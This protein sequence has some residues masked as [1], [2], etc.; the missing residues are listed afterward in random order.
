MAKKKGNDD[1]RE[2]IKTYLKYHPKADTA[3]IEE[4]YHFSK[5]RHKRQLRLSKEPYIVHP[6]GAAKIIAEYRSDEVMIAATLLHDVLEDTPVDYKQLRKL[7]GKEICQL[8][9]G[10]TN[11]DRAAFKSRQENNIANLEKILE[12]GSKDIRVVLI[13]LAD[14][15]DNMKTLGFVPKEKQKRI[16]VDVLA[17]Y[18]PLAHR[19]GLYRIGSELEDLAFQ[20]IN[21]EKYSD[22]KKKIEIKRKVKRKEINKAIKLLKK[23][24][25]GKD[26]NFVVYDKSI[27]STYHKMLHHGKI[28]AEIN[29][30]VLVFILTNDINE[31]YCALGKLHALFRPL[32]K[33]LKDHIAIPKSELH[34]A[35]HTTVIGP[36]KKPLKFY[37]STKEFFKFYGRGVFRY[38][39]A[40]ADD[41]K[42][43]NKR[44]KWLAEITHSP[45][46]FRTSSEMADW[47]KI[48]DL[49]DV[50]FVF[51]SKDK[52]IELSPKSTVLDFAFLTSPKK[53]P[54]CFMARINGQEAPLDHVLEAGNIVELVY[55]KRMQIGESW[56]RKVHSKSAKRLISEELSKN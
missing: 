23:E 1:L 22:L 9:E 35:I 46:K 54:Y 10:V 34:R 24:F 12:A 48:S 30:N 4:A 36:D 43:L 53:A 25:V 7:F 15:L 50:I 13:K 3:L 26:Y 44:T 2:L 20:H 47:L 16:A 32:P 49:F 39:S 11:W 17:L 14:K 41:K 6:V 56:L 18:G 45:F 38:L 21:P 5:S 8:V 37:I 42:T 19:L 51:N 31:A 52:I 40:D 28:L 27:Y 55:S 29:D 33:K